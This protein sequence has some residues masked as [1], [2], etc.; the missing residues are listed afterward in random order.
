MDDGRVRPERTKDVAL[1]QGRGCPRHPGPTGKALQYFC[2]GHVGRFTHGGA[3]NLRG[4]PGIALYPA[5]GPGRCQTAGLNPIQAEGKN[6][7][8][9]RG[10]IPGVAEAI[11]H[12]G[13][14]K[15]GKISGPGA[16]KDGLFEEC[17]GVP[18]GH[19]RDVIHR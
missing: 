19:A 12:S 7:R 10:S 4:T 15:Q 5:L 9:D 18:V 17:Q 14:K 16:G 3:T 8:G 1:P 2:F 13:L 6:P 11:R